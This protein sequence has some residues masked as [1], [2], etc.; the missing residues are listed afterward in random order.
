MTVSHNRLLPPV[1]FLL[2]LAALVP[3]YL[4][5]PE[6]LGRLRTDREMPWDVVL[7]LGLAFLLGA[8]YQF[9]RNN[10]EIMTFE[11]PR[12]L[13]TSG[14]FRISR[15]PM[16]LGFILLLTAAAFYVNTICALLAPIVFFAAAQWWYIPHEENAARKAFGKDYEAYANKVRRWL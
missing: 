7:I 14:L 6:S 4:Y 8:R 11:E 1:L 9:S 2:L 13:V 15:N 16:Y 12:N 10:S 5:H 3:L